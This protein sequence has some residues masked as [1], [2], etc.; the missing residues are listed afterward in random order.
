MIPIVIYIEHKKM[1][2]I[3]WNTTATSEGQALGW[4]LS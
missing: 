2:E 1:A 4:E 3:G